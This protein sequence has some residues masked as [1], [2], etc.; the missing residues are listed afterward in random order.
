MAVAKRQHLEKNYVFVICFLYC[1]KN[2]MKYFTFFAQ[3]RMVL[4]SGL[5]INDP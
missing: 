4:D 1:I 3:S 5:K 2:N